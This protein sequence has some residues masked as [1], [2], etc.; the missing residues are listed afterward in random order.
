MTTKEQLINSITLA[1]A[2]SNDYSVSKLR[3]IIRQEL[4]NYD[5]VEIKETLPSVGDGSATIYLFGKFAQAK[6]TVGM[7]KTTLFQYK[8]AVVSLC[9]FAHKELNFITEEDINMWVLSMRRNDLSSST[10]NNRFRLVSS[11]FSFLFN[12]KYIANNPIIDIEAPKLDI[13][14]KKVI[15]EKEM[16]Q[17]LVACESFGGINAKRKVAMVDFLYDTMVRVSEFCSIKISDVDFDNMSAVVFGKG[18]KERIVYFTESTLV[19][20]KEY[21]NTRN[22]IKNVNGTLVYA[23]DAPL[24]ATFSSKY[25]RLKKCT[26]EEEVRQIGKVSGI[27]RI[28]PHLFRATKATRLAEKGVDIM[29]IAKLL[30]H[31]NLHTINRYVLLSEKRMKDIIKYA[32]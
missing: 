12:H 1:I 10:I 32:A 23:Q 8:Y 27:E 11:V 4:F 19:R 5:V 18:G 3:E 26:V 9:N 14:I 15:S 24:F 13:K 29:V 2:E 16:E 28:H 30:G 6:I 7:N 22:D 17:I 21:L 31:S 20:L 25:S